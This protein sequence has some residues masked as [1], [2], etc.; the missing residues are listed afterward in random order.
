MVTPTNSTKTPVVLAQRLTK[1]FGDFWMRDKVRAVDNLDFVIEPGQIF[2]L[3]G[4]NGSGKSTTIKMILG[5]LHKTSGRLAVFGKTPNDLSVKNRIG[6]LPE[7]SYLYP[8]L[9]ARETLDF[10]GKLFRLDRRTRQ[11]RIDELLDMV[12]LDAVQR[13]P[14]GQF[15]KGMQRRVGIGQAL[16]NDPDFLILDEP[17][18]GLDPLGI[19]QVKDLILD[20]GKRGKTIL[21]SSHLLSEVED[22]CDSMTILYGG[23]KRAEGTRE[24]LLLADD[25]TVIEVDALTPEKA[26]EVRRFIEDH[27]GKRVRS[28]APARQ[29]LESLFLNIVEEAQ[30]ER[31]ETHGAKAGGPTAAFLRGQ[32]E[33]SEASAPEGEALIDSLVADEPA[34]ARPAT[35][36]AVAEPESAEPASDESD[37]VLEDL[38]ADEEPEPP[39]APT[40]STPSTPARPTPAD[41]DVDRSVIDSLL[42]SDN[43]P[44]DPKP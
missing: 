12:G 14:I 16:I 34:S 10:Y 31:L 20:L 38:L 41:D 26:E 22:V 28:L 30:R 23:K 4:P 13:R 25:R 15:S 19:R 21:L 7:E 42:D 36:G 35:E 11:R 9:N 18:S 43:R 8:F 5:L 32:T 24:E 29:S 39:T 44:T 2:G 6:Y 1:V 17:T 27:E 3:I 33:P 37:Q 40:P